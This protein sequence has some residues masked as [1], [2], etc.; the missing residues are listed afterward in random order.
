MNIHL[1][2]KCFLIGLSVAS[3]VGPIF[4]LTFNHAVWGGFSR[5]FATAL[6]AALGDGFLFLLGLLGVL[7]LLGE[8]QGTL[9]LLDALGSFLLIALAIRSFKGHQKYT[10]DTQFIDLDPISMLIKSFFLT[11]ANPLTVLF[12]MFIGMRIFPEGI[13]AITLRHIGFGSF[14]TFLGSLTVLSIV[15]LLASYL[16]NAINT[17]RLRTISYITGSIFFAI[18]IYFS[19]DFVI[20]LIDI[21]DL[22]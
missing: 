9:L 15:S 18:G 21:I 4:V 22:L 2:L 1:Y 17:K 3:A 14:F 19:I 13:N 6:G 7:R 10:A 20:R 16:G 12:F 11:V 5:G 8:Y